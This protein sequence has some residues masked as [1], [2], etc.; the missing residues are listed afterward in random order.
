M[1]PVPESESG[2]LCSWLLEDGGQARG[3]GA[4]PG[5]LDDARG[6]ADLAG[7]ERQKDT[8]TAAQQELAAISSKLTHKTDQIATLELEVADL[9]SQLAVMSSLSRTDENSEQ[10]IRELHD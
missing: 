10:H 8:K 9:Q 5:R 6:V 1:K 4:L 7:S 2:S 3:L